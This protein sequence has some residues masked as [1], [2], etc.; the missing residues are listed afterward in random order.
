MKNLFL[1]LLGLSLTQC[2]NG[3]FYRENIKGNGKTTEHTITISDY[4]A[5]SI[6]GNFEV[7]L[8]QAAEGKLDFIIEDN[9]IE[10]L[11][12]RVENDKLIIDWDNAY[13]IRNANDVILKIPVTEISKLSLAGSTKLVS[14][15]KFKF[16]KLDLSVAGSSN[17]LLDIDTNDLKVSLAG[18]TH[19]VMNGFAENASINVAGSGDFKGFGL[20]TKHLK[21]SVAGSGDMEIY[22]QE[23]LKASVAGS[24]SILYKGNPKED[25]ISVAGSGKIKMWN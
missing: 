7:E 17:I 3:Q 22:A 23:S 10:Y 8:Y 4:D 18:S 12:V 19:T 16:D 11:D 15:N 14:K 21:A 25:K 24:G 13:H 20:V 2:A 6:A 5:V 9:L 1:I